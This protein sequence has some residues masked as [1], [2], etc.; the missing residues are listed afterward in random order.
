[1]EIDDKLKR[2]IKELGNAINESLSES[3]RISDVMG[4]IR[5]AGYDLFL[6]LEVTVGFNK[7]EEP[8]RSRRARSSGGRRTEVQQFHLTNEDAEFLRDLNISV[9]VD[10]DGR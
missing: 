5:A 9:D 3:D 10:E 8:G 2:L 7:H 1:L 6:V 4:K